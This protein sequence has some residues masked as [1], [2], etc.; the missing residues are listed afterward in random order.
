MSLY[1]GVWLYQFLLSAPLCLLVVCF[2]GQALRTRR[3]RRTG[4]W[5]PT[6]K[7]RHSTGRLTTDEVSIDPKAPDWP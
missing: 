5:G 6:R 2:V 1:F 7:Q 3:G 4:E